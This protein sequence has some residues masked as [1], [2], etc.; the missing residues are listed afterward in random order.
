MPYRRSR[1]QDYYEQL[2]GDKPSN[3]G[4]DQDTEQ[5]PSSDSAGQGNTG[6]FQTDDSF[7]SNWPWYY[8]HLL[9][10]SPT[11]QSTGQTPDSDSGGQG[12]TAASQAE[13]RPPATTR[14]QPVLVPPD[15]LDLNP[16]T[17]G[18]IEQHIAALN[19][20]QSTSGF[21]QD[22]EWS[23]EDEPSGLDPF[24]QAAAA[25]TRDSSEDKTTVVCEALYAA[26]PEGFARGVKL[27][28]GAELDNEEEVLGECIRLARNVGMDQYLASEEAWYTTKLGS[29]ESPTVSAAE[30]ES[31]SDQAQAPAEADGFEQPEISLLLQ[32]ALTEAFP[33]EWNAGW[34]EKQHLQGFLVSD[35]QRII[36]EYDETARVVPGFEETVINWADL[37]VEEMMALYRVEIALEFAAR[38]EHYEG[39][40]PPEHDEMKASLDRAT[41]LESLAG[42]IALDDTEA[43]AAAFAG[44]VRI[45]DAHDERKHVQDQLAIIYKHLNIETPENYL[46]SRSTTELKYELFYRLNY[47]VQQFMSLDENE[48]GNRIGNFVNEYIEETRIAPKDAIGR[49]QSTIH[50]PDVLGFLFIMG[51]SIAFEPVDYALAA[52]DVIQALSEGDEEAALGNFILGVTPFVSSKMDDLILPL[53]KRAGFKRVLPISSWNKAQR[54]A[55][56]QG[57]VTVPGSS[58]GLHKELDRLDSRP[59]DKRYNVNWYK[60]KDEV[61]RISGNAENTIGLQFDELGYGVVTKPTRTQLDEIGYWSQRKKPDF[62]IEDRVFDAIAVN[63]SNERSI[64]DRINEKLASGQADNIVLDITESNVTLQNLAKQFTKWGDGMLYNLGE[65]L[66]LEQLWIRSNDQLFPFLVVENQKIIML[67]P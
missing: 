35:L 34:T 21:P 36:P 40:L 17:V 26:D 32:W 52:V 22:I 46:D 49:L 55:L 7:D 9:S 58:G 63:T 6:G 31:L 50:Q 8:S 24:I 1:L 48:K 57:R 54:E 18:S 14:P 59:V 56:E 38:A 23:P 27:M 67:W 41:Q 3:G 29:S 10:S 19:S 30:E 5:A 16:D 64:A 61:N 45:A 60:E 44:R 42:P 62:I 65:G 20:G 47:D 25:R 39:V 43:Y 37:T 15:I 33:G 53:L 11:E 66:D 28:T 13:I 2:L 4:T 12:G 51:L